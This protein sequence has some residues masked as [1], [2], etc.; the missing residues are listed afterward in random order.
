MPKD[1]ERHAFAPCQ[2]DQLVYA[3][4]KP[5]RVHLALK[6]FYLFFMVEISLESC[7]IDSQQNRSSLLETDHNSLMPWHMSARLDQLDTWHQFSIPID[8]PV[9]Q[10]RMIPMWTCD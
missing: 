9:A 6:V 1:H 10:A 4:M 8:E 2:F 7:R 3:F 5:G